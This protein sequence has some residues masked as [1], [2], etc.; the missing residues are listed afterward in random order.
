MAQRMDEWPGEEPAYFGTSGRAI[1]RAAREMGMISSWWNAF[2][3]DEVLDLLL[4]DDTD[5]RHFG[6]V[7]IGTNWYSSMYELQDDKTL[8]VSP[9]AR[10]DGGHETCLI[11]ANTNSETFYAINSW[12]DMRLF[13]LSFKTFERLLNEDGDAI[14][15]V[16]VP[17][18]R[19]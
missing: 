6:P 14:F 13:R 19:P 11:G 9:T 3:V 1:C 5:W 18:V 7:I 8:I 16:E 12:D 15:P 2:T 4:A 17:R 10:V